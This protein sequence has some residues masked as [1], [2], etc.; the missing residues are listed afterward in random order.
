[1]TQ[2]GNLINN[3]PDRYKYE[4]N[5]SLVLSGCRIGIEIELEELNEITPRNNAES[6]ALYRDLYYYWKIVDDGSLRNYG[7]GLAKEFVL[8]KGLFGTDLLDSLYIFDKY[9]HSL[10]VKPKCSDRTSVHIHLD[11]RNLEEEELTNLILLYTFSERVLFKYCGEERNKNIYCLSFE[12]A[13]GTN[14][15][16][17]DM[18]PASYV[19]NITNESRYSALNLASISKFGTL[20]FRH[21]PGTYDIGRMTEWINIIMSLKRACREIKI[22]AETPGRISSMGILN[23]F[24]SVYKKYADKLFYTGIE[25]D[26]LHGLRLAQEILLKNSL[27]KYDSAIIR[28]YGKNGPGIK[29]YCRK[30]ALNLKGAS[31]K[32]RNSRV[33]NNSP[34][35]DVV[36]NNGDRNDALELFEEA[37]R[38]AIAGDI[39]PVGIRRIIN[40]AL[41]NPGPNDNNEGGV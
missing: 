13:Q 10:K 32:K 36:E 24:N 4:R 33:Y 16:V 6:S 23:F 20:E 40:P 31:A 35:G 30:H 22:D 27:R 21:H 8:L 39:R 37:A 17:V 1:M 3:P 12:E 29:A 7:G 28:T 19:H 34:D 5:K 15:E 41:L 38:V 26:L 9:V 2:L 11:V 25:A 18:N 14:F